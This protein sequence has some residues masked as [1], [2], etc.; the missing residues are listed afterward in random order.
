MSKN[1]LKPGTPQQPTHQQPSPTRVERPT[2]AV[3]PKPEALKPVT[4]TKGGW[5]YEKKGGKG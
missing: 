3:P 4:I 5:D 1:P 2:T